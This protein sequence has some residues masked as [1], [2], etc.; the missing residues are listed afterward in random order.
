MTG[1][2]ALRGTRE[3]SKSTMNYILVHSTVQ[4]GLPRVFFQGLTYI[5][6]YSE[7]NTATVLEAQLKQVLMAECPQP[8]PHCPQR[9]S[10]TAHQRFGLATPKVQSVA[11]AH[12]FSY[13]Y[14]VNM[15]PL[16][17][18][19]F[20][21]QHGYQVVGTNT[22]GDTCIWTLEKQTRTTEQITAQTSEQSATQ[23]AFRIYPTY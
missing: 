16:A 7:N 3:I 12:G 22:I 4:R 9:P 23:A 21:K 20:L 11:S 19:E 5:D 1:N 18:L 8:K 17:V 10:Q 15:P 6:Y 14:T 13:N 2:L